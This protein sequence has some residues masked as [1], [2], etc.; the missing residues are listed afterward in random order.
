MGAGATR[1][2]VRFSI[3]LFWRFLIELRYLYVLFIALDACFRLKRRK[4]SSW[5]R[6][7]ALADGLSYLV[8]SAPFERYLETEGKDQ[9]EVCVAQLCL[10]TCL[11]SA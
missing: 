7:P 4:I 11:L 5:E 3:L 2:T 1:G 9:N 8:E 6:D 10:P